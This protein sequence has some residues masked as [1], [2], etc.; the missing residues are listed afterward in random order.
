MNK[1]IEKAVIPAA[2]Y[3]T[4]MLPFTKAVP[5]ELI[6]LVDT[7]VLQYVAE[8]AVDAGAKKILFTISDGKEAVID[9]F[10]KS[11]GLE[12]QLKQC[13]KDAL[14]LKMQ[15]L[16]EL[17]EFSFVYQ[18]ELNGLGGAVALA[19]DFVGNDPFLVLLG[20]TVID[21]PRGNNASKELINVYN[22]HHSPVVAVTPV[23]EEKISSYGIVAGK[24]TVR[25]DVLLLDDIVE[26]PGVENAPGN[27]AVTARYLLTPDIFQALNET[28]HGV[29]N[30]IQLTDAIRKLLH[31]RPFYG[32]KISGRRY[33]LG[34]VSGFLTA[35]VVFALRH[36]ELGKQLA[37]EIAD[38][39]K[40]K[41]II[42]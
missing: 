36:P 4:R 34:S 14:L 6:P 17:A 10:K 30:E 42:E 11:A 19:E 13:G 29:N 5:K 15:K 41:N 3:G 26:K 22:M 38:I 21:S 39:L 8:E 37:R 24:E 35:N 25:D 32:C 28:G 7:P 31:K 20:D 40:E 18:R 2:G 1:C 16:S 23:P 9:H 33:D 27:L 12:K